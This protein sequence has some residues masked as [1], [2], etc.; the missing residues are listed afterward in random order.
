MSMV[1]DGAVPLDGGPAR[2]LSTFAPGPVHAV[3]GIGHPESFFAALRAHGLDVIGHPF[4][5][6]HAFVAADLAF[7]PA[8]PLL[9]TEKDAVK[10]A[11]AP[12][13]TFAVPASA[14][15]PAAF[16]DALRGRLADWTRT[17]APA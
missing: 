10:L 5:D 7:A 1:L 4:P 3:A 8:A 6:H 17:D 11:D 14:C 16:F 13:G 2:A 9:L 12:R 15:L